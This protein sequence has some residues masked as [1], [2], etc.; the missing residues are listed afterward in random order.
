MNISVFKDSREVSSLDFGQEISNNGGN[1]FSFFVGRSKDCHVVLDDMQ[2]SREHAKVS[3][4]S[5]AWTIQKVSEFS[6]VSINGS[7]QDSHVLKNGDV[8]Q[9]GPYTI[10]INLPVVE[11]PTPPEDSVGLEESSD[12]AGTE[13]FVAAPMP[14]DDGLTATVALD[15]GEVQGALSD[16]DSLEDDLD[17]DL[18]DLDG[19]DGLEDDL[20]GDLGDLDGDLGDLDGEN[21]EFAGD[22]EFASG[23]DD[24]NSEEGDFSSE[25]GFSDGEFSDDGEGDFSEDGEFSG[26]DEYDEYSEDGDY[27]MEE[28]GDEK[29]QVLK[30][31]AKISFD[32]FGEFAPYDK[33]VVEERET[34][35]GRDPEKCQIVLN[36]PEVSGVHAVIKKTAI[37]CVLEDLKSGNGTL[38]NGERVNSH[39]ITNGD[40]FIIGSTTFTVNISSDFLAQEESRLMPV[41][42]NQVVEVEEILEVDTNFAEGEDGEDFEGGEFGEADAGP[43]DKSLLGKWKK[44]NQKQKIIYGGAI[45]M[46]LWFLL[47][48]ESKPPPKKPDPKKKEQLAKK[49]DKGIKS[50]KSQKP[51]TKEEM[52]FL[53]SRYKLAKAQFEI[54]NY[55]ETLDELSKIHAIVDQWKKSKELEGW[56]K[57]GLKKLEDLAEKERR[58][59]LEAERKIKVQGLVKKAT[60]AVNAHNVPLAQGLFNQIAELDPENFELTQLKIQLDAWIKK[61][62]AEALAKAQAEAERNRQVQALKPG[63]TFYLK[64]E[65]YK[66][67]LKLESFLRTEGLE[68]EYMNEA[69]KMLEESRRNLDDIIEPLLGKA[70]SLKEGQDLKGAYEH[71]LKI[72]DYNPGQEEALN[73]MDKIQRLL[74]SRSKRVYRE[75]IIAESLSL[76]DEAREKFQEVQQ[77][78]PSDSEY[79][80]KATEKLKD[81]LE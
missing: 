31:F 63:K 28:S 73:E 10:N 45:L 79:Y 71:F 68:D 4:E 18:G 64:K 44:L 59:K 24:F 48:E 40:E 26:E 81:Y 30:T 11:T 27:A 22:D 60:D 61:K 62:D 5:G 57:E 74:E 56:A 35:V 34:F 46:G 72:L 66:A 1:P 37:N 15:E 42:E 69:T 75:A 58:A 54:G 38:L 67:I 6:N 32:L 9:I 78:S 53:D 23:E 70:R 47:G 2:V 41:E 36:D 21:S 52:E 43:E 39:E 7:F 49:D 13:T 80:K 77:I 50:K 65:W 16:E 51:L 33:F 19:G 55:R 25:D 12:S 76:F 3:Y 17:G 14:S 20:D 29:T 8:V